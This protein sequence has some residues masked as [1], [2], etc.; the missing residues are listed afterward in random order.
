MSAAVSGSE[1]VV[2]IMPTRA[3][4][5]DRADPADRADREMPGSPPPERL[6]GWPGLGFDPVPGKPDLVGALAGRLAAVTEALREVQR[7]LEPLRAVPDGW[8]GVAA[9]A[10]AARCADLPSR[11]DGLRR[12]LVAAEGTL[13]GWQAAMRQLRDRAERVEVRARLARHELDAATEVA[14]A[15]RA[16]PDLG[17][18]G[19]RFATDEA[20]AEAQHRL[21][22]A[23][24]GVDE[25][26]AEVHR[27]RATGAELARHGE[28]LG[29]EHRAGAEQTAFALLTA[30]LPA[31]TTTAPPEEPRPEEPPAERPRPTRG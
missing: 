17:L 4:R 14:E 30:A 26:Q 6:S 25:A 13:L 15:A 16:H 1:P 5:A 24:A 20:L 18:D 11:L 3:D 8:S 21:D 29:R 31:T 23:L 10:F 12:S 27:A 19:Q 7:L 9:D 22:T 2:V 28:L